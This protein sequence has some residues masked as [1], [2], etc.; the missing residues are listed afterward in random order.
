MG[1]INRRICAA[2]AGLFLLIMFPGCKDAPQEQ[3]NN[4]IRFTSINDIPGITQDEIRAIEKLKESGPFVYG[5]MLSTEAFHD[6]KGT[7]RGYVALFCEWMNELF[8]IRFEPAL[9]EWGELINGLESH[10][11][12]FTGELT[13]TD[14]RRKTHFMTDAIAERSIKYMRIANSESLAGIAAARPLRYAFLEGTTT[15]DDVSVYENRVF[16]PVLIDDYDDA[17]KLLK[18][19]KVD[20]FFE[21]GTAEAAFDIY[22]DVVASDFFPLIYG[23]VSLTTQN[24]ALEPVISAVQKVLQ[25][26]GIRYLTELYNT[27]HLEYIKHKMDTVLTAEEHA[28]INKKNVVR[29]AAEY[30]NYPLSFYNTHE[31]QWQ[32]IAHDVLREIEKLTGLSFEVVNGQST[33]WPFLINML[34]NGSAA[35]VS[36]LIQIRER[37]GRF[38]WADTPLTTSNYA[39]I[40]KSEYRNIDINEILFAKVGLVTGTAYGQLFKSWFPSHANTV[41]YDSMDHAVNALENGEVDLL[42]ASD[43]HLLILTNYRELPGYK[44]NVVF[45][46]SFDSKFGFNK[47]EVILRSIINKALQL[48][49]VHWLAEQWLRKT[50]DYRLTLTRERTSWLVGAT[51]LL[52]VLVFVFVLF[53]KNR[54]AGKQLEK[55]VNDR[56]HELTRILSQMETLISNY[57]G[58]IWNVDNEGVIT[59]FNGRYLQ[60][61]GM[62]SSQIEGR[63]LELAL[64]KNGHADIIENVKKT[65]QEG[66]PQTWMSE[67]NG[68][69]FNSR[70]VPI[71]D[72]GGKIFGVVGSTDDV[73]ETVRLQREMQEA[74]IAA[75]EANRA[76]SAFL[77]NM[78]HEIRTPMNSIIGFS[79]LALDDEISQKTQ[80]YLSKIKENASWLL[81]IINDILDISKVESG[82]MELETIP[83][84]VDDVLNRCQAIISPKAS[85]KGILLHFYAEPTIGKVLLG[86]PTRLGQVLINILGNAVKFTNVGAIKLSAIASLTTETRC[87]ITFSIRDSG[88]GMT[89]EQ[90]VKVFEPF[91]QADTSTTRKY[92]GTGLGLSI[93]K[94]IIEL[95]GGELK[96][97]SAPGIGS[98]FSFD[99]TF[100]TMNMPEGVTAVLTEGIIEK[101]VFSGET[102]LVCEDNSMNQLVITENLSKLEIKTVIAENG[103]I[104]VDLVKRRMENGEPNFDLI[105]MD[106]H[107]PVMD[108][109]EA[110][111]KIMELGTGTPIVAMTANI[112]SNDKELYKSIGIK[113]F[114]GKPFTSQ[115]LWRCLLKYLKPAESMPVVAGAPDSAPSMLSEPPSKEEVR[116]KQGDDDLMSKL[117]TMFVKE[118]KEK[119]KEIADAIGAGDIKLAHRLAHTLKSNAGQLGKTALQKAANDV[120][121]LLKDDKNLTTKDHMNTLAAELDAALKELAP[122]AEVAIAAQ[123]EAGPFDIE[124]ARELL[125]ALEPLLKDGNPECMNMTG[126][127]GAIPGS[128]E[129][130][131]QIEDFDFEPAVSTLDEL[132]KKIGL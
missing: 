111:P 60:S 15:F 12:D 50:Y 62:K 58:I 70:A 11:I 45:N 21:E 53:Q 66:S 86:D 109:L 7:V 83:F 36:D 23:P 13:A 89:P 29:F 65:F 2:L 44:A 35:M 37:E 110:T 67:I 130:I 131:R 132:K 52:L 6:D 19:G 56:T 94:S 101:P 81:Q 26:G 41:E 80:G 90:I 108:G 38:L 9:Y 129:L 5:A 54:N 3:S 95:M 34:E 39:L 125:S 49:D 114:V 43:Q 121:A 104:G 97:E 126:D 112:M 32:G 96:V 113:D 78:S 107:M 91:A 51:V 63:K 82:K 57:K 64:N 17:Y 128:E 102:I 123:S 75:Q 46:R 20:A 27:G 93:T 117:K 48:T 28:Y 40:S 33:E 22:G 124:K 47:D 100:N 18:S 55:L 85:E 24:P 25:N 10:K 59:I 127:I 122:F 14:E 72:G 79:E 87:T 31:G 118:N 88:I 77:A 99:L 119:A 8:G 16:E 120:E 76:K 116:Q 74:I 71:Y 103:Q 84:K 1:T 61:I 68:G 115:E 92:G 30:D 42:M 4:S 73:T 98:K 69:V 105:F 106:M